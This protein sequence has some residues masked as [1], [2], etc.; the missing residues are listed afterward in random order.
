MNN[1]EEFLFFSPN[2]YQERET[3]FFDN[4]EFDQEPVDII[5]SKLWVKNFNNEIKNKN[6]FLTTNIFDDQ[7]GFTS[8]IKLNKSSQFE[9]NKIQ[10]FIIV[11]TQ[12][13]QKNNCFDKNSKINED[14]NQPSGENILLGRKKKG[15]N[16]LGVHTKFTDDNLSRKFKHIIIDNLLKY[17]NSIIKNQYND[18]IGIGIGEKKLLKLNQRQ[19]ISSKAD[20]NQKFLQTSIK[21][22]LSDNISKKY[23]NY[24]PYHNKILIENLL[25]EDNLEKRILFR[26]IFNLSFL[27]CIKHFKGEAHIN[28]LE[29]FIGLDEVCKNFEKNE[30][31]IDYIN[32]FKWYV[33]NFED[34]IMDKKVR[35]RKSKKNIEINQMRN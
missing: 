16:E 14:K 5:T 3:L 6:N 29:G 34:I 24:P 4:F 20:F 7:T 30:D 26:K 13:N 2:E 11:G 28:E 21:D 23:S 27:D 22:I 12:K 19:I 15:S 32:Q 18:S 25:N 9:F 31:D 17:I 33:K 8:K 35:N 10:D 1:I